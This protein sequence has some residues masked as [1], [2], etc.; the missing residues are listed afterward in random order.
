MASGSRGSRADPGESR[1]GGYSLVATV[2][3]ASAR[4]LVRACMPIVQGPCTF[5]RDLAVRER[6]VERAPAAFRMA[7]V[8]HHAGN[9]GRVLAA[10]NFGSGDVFSISSK[11]KPMNN[12]WTTATRN[13]GRTK[14]GVMRQG[15]KLL[16]V[17]GFVATLLAPTLAMA[18][19]ETGVITDLM[20]CQSSGT[21]YLLLVR[22]NGSWYQVA[23]GSEGPTENSTEINTRLALAAALAGKQVK[24]R[25]HTAAGQSCGVPV[26]G[27]IKRDGV[28]YLIMTP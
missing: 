3:S 23:L 21:D 10:D 13:V 20:T 28:D 2:L 16:A 15:M 14:V 27:Y 4:A 22:V 1:S 26:A 24:I 8:L 25:Y 12:R 11:E 7:Y 17:A 5:G 18:D 6:G 19:P 9:R